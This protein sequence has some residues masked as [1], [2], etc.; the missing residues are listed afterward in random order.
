MA[1]EIHT[2]VAGDI[3]PK[4][5]VWQAIKTGA[6]CRCPKCG[7]GKIFGKWLKVER[8]CN[9]C[10]EELYHEKAQD[11]PPYITI[12]IVGHIM[13][14]LIMMV[15]GNVDWSLQT[16]LLIWLPLSLILTLAIMQPVKGAVV[17]MQWALR[18]FGFDGLGNDE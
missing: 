13:V 5:S 11:F 4:R 15:E 9:N 3:L 8:K 17:G 14:T 2:D 12:M 6:K 16:H 18:M 7:D 1:V 10:G